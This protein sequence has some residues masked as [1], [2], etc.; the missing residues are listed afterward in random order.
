LPARLIVTIPEPCAMIGRDGLNSCTSMTA[1]K[2]PHGLIPQFVFSDSWVLVEGRILDG[3]TGMGTSAQYDMCDMI[4]RCS[5]PPGNPSGLHE[6]RSI[7][8]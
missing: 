5:S 3:V 1:V 7:G 2:I 4:A 6:R 8:E